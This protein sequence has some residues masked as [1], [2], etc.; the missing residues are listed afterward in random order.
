MFFCL[1]LIE[2]FDMLNPHHS[3]ILDPIKNGR[4]VQTP[5]KLYHSPPCNQIFC[6]R[7]EHAPVINLSSLAIIS[8]SLAYLYFWNTCASI[9]SPYLVYLYSLASFHILVYEKSQLRVAVCRR[10]CSLLCCWADFLVSRLCHTSFEP[11]AIPNISI[12]IL[13]WIV[14]LLHF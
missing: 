6:H 7:S 9:I 13:R 10:A 3:N 2:L 8:I 4:Q 11:F 5:F 1:I 12:A 14:S